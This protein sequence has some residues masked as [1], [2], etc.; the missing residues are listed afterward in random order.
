MEGGLFCKDIG[1]I[2][3]KALFFCIVPY[4]EA[5]SA[6]ELIL[7][8]TLGTPLDAGGKLNVHK[9]FHLSPVFRGEDVTNL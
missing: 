4:I 5:L 3:S 9:T 7:V 8:S 6:Y 2:P 1:I